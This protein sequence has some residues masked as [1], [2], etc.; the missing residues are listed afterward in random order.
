MHNMIQLFR[1]EEVFR[2]FAHFCVSFTRNCSSTR[3]INYKTP[4]ILLYRSV[5][6][7]LCH[8]QDRTDR[9]GQFLFHLEDTSVQS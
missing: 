2:D 9:G 3:V 8:S 1:N 4:L 7:D 6:M 5:A